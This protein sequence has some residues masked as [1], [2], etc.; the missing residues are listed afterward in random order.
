MSSNWTHMVAV[1]LFLTFE[2]TQ[3]KDSQSSP[4]GKPFFIR[5]TQLP[6]KHWLIGTNLKRRAVFTQNGPKQLSFF[7]VV[8][9]QLSKSLLRKSPVFTL[10][11]DSTLLES[12]SLEMA[13]QES[14]FGSLF[15][16]SEN[17]ST[18]KLTIIQADCMQR[19]GIRRSKHASWNRLGLGNRK[20]PN[21]L[22]YNPYSFPIYSLSIALEFSTI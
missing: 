7:K 10:F 11:L 13:P 8:P 17:L 20:S 3:K 22:S 12:Q 21:R 14:C 15:F 5:I 6:L 18:E 4:L 1:I 16:L 19:L 9:F 2:T